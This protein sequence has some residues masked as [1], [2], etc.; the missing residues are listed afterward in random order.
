MLEKILAKLL[1]KAYPNR[2]YV[3]ER[4]GKQF[5]VYARDTTGCNDYLL[6]GKYSYDQVVELN[7]LTTYNASYGYCDEIGPVAFIGI[8]NHNCVGQFGY[9][10][11]NVNEYG[12]GGNDREYYFKPY[13]DEEAKRINNYTVYGMRA[14]NDGFEEICKVARIS[15]I[16]YVY[17]SRYD[18]KNIKQLKVFDMDCK[19][20]GTYD[21]YAAKVLATGT[22]KEKE[23]YSGEEHPIIFATVGE[24]YHVGI[25]GIWES[26]KK[27]I[28][29]FRDVWEYG[30]EE[31]K[32]EK[33]KVLSDEEAK[34]IKEF[35]LYIYDYSFLCVK[36]KYHIE[37][38]DRTLDKRFF[39]HL[40]NGKDYRLIEHKELLREN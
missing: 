24:N 3:V 40:P 17:D 32:I 37:K 36:K 25:I 10:K 6:E 22:R 2:D 8:P 29:G 7:A 28:S 11:Y 1:K 20:S 18:A 5:V 15:K 23:T 27:L 38:C 30:N 4:N 34:K 19:L 35:S 13:T 21:Y 33:I 39:F 16:E 14:R 31:P 26:D 12:S 9:F